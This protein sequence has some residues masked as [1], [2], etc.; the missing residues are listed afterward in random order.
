[1]RRWIRRAI[2]IGFAVGALL[3]AQAPAHADAICG[4]V[5]TWQ[6]VGKHYFCVP[7]V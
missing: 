4:R 1:M 3:G 2:V 6:P 7:T 5:G